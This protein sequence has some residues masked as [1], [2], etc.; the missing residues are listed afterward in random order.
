MRFISRSP[1]ILRIL[2]AGAIRSED[3]KDFR[4]LQK[5]Y[6]AGYGVRKLSGRKMS[7][8]LTRVVVLGIAETPQFSPKGPSMAKFVS[9]S[10]G[11]AGQV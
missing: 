7:F 1:S 6:E 9:E 8:E 2:A 10:R 5:E 3:T 4:E 11:T